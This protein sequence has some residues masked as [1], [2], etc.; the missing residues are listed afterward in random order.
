MDP[1]IVSL[2]TETPDIIKTLSG[3]HTQK[4]GAELDPIVHYLTLLRASQ[5]NK[6][7]FCIDMHIREALEVGESQ[8]RIDRVIVWR[9]V[10]DFTAREKAAFAWT[11]ALTALDPH[12]DMTELRAD[13][14]AHFTDREIALLTAAVAMINLW[15]RINVAVERPI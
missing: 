13:L 4:I 12:T 1:N 10:D 7:A 6:C 15:N 14:K 11:E 8:Q 3:L 2:E 5:I 9:E